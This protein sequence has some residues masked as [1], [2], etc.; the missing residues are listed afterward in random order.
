MHRNE[1]EICI[2]S[3]DKIPVL[4]VY[5]DRVETILLFSRGVAQVAPG[6]EHGFFPNS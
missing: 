6:M 1:E 3:R 2:Y 4:V 5:L